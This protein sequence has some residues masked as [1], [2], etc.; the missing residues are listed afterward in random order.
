MKTSIKF[1]LLLSILPV[2]LLITGCTRMGS[3]PHDAYSENSANFTITPA[4]NQ[5]G[6]SSDQKVQIRFVDP[7]DPAL[8]ENNF[9]LISELDIS[10]STCR[11]DPTMNHSNMGMSMMDTLKMGHIIRYHA[12][13]GRFTWSDGNKLCT[14]TPDSLLKSNMSY[15]IYIGKGM[16]QSGMG[17]MGGMGGHG[18]TTMQ[19]NMMFHFRTK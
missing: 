9:H 12:T 15:M 18:G 17:N 4:N 13:G 5:S 3:N 11:C 19:E 10:D 16:M 6:I 14:F 8:V 7:V 2:I 1:I